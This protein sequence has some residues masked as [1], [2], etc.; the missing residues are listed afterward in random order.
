MKFNNLHKF[1]KCPPVGRKGEPMWMKFGNTY[2]MGK[3]VGAI[4]GLDFVIIDKVLVCQVFCCIARFV[5]SIIVFM[6]SSSVNPV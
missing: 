3:S 2:S 4:C 5:A 1:Y 6:N